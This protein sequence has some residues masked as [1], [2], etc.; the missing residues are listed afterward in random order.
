MKRIKYF[1]IPLLITLFSCNDGFLEKQPLDKLSEDAVFN[2]ENLLTSY[3]NGLYSVM[4]QPYTEGT[5]AAITDEAFF[6]YGGT[7]TNY[8]ARGQMTPDNVIYM[9]EGGPAHNSRMLY[10]N[11]WKRAYQYIRDMNVFFE[12]IDEAQVSTA[13]KKQLTG[14]VYFLRAWAY[15]NLIWRYAGVPIITNTYD[16]Y[17]DFNATRDN[18]DDCVDFILADIDSA[19]VYLPD[20]AFDKGRACADACLALKSRL[21]L[22]AASPLF[23]DPDDSQ[24]SIF[25]G[26]YDKN[27]WVA[28]KNAAKAVIDRA[29]AG[30][31]ALCPDYTQIWSDANNK[32]LIWGIFF[33]EFSGLSAQSYYAPEYNFLGWTACTPYENIV[34]DY[35]MKATGK[36]PFEPG[37]G[38]DP[39]NPWS[40]RDPRFYKTIIYPNSVFRGDTIKMC[41]SYDMRRVPNDPYYSE[42]TQCTGYWLKKWHIEDKIISETENSTILYPW[43]RLAEFYL[44]YAEACLNLEDEVECRKYINKVRDRADVMM[45]HVTETG[46]ALREKLINERRIE[47]AFEKH[48]YFDLRRWKLAEIYENIS[49]RGI[50]LIKQKNGTIVYQ[51]AKAGADG[52]P[53]Y[54]DCRMTAV[55]KKFFPQHY[56]MPIPSNEMLKSE[57]SLIQNPYY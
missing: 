20:K 44:N 22:Y 5:V 50:T 39:A 10:L 42:A 29:D 48:R 52:K 3:V 15:A 30:A 45:P 2:N 17:D 25:K 4:Y 23:N 26:T 54:S 7:S 31:Y 38:Y 41:K 32:E 37:S 16:I 49:G 53:D 12:N 19:L 40:G 24:G 1:I 33:N 14:E 8:I 46:N 55:E 36:K 28:A 13:V 27:K 56:L 43:F 6:R 9:V 35:E 57:G 34:C 11:I 21:L 47:L 51:I 18:Y